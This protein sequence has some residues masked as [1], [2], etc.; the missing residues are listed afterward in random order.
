MPDVIKSNAAPTALT[1]TA[2]T[3]YTTPGSTTALVRKITVCNVTDSSV[4][5][6]ASKG[7]DAVA[8]RVVRTTIPAGE[9]LFLPIDLPLAA[10]EV[11]QMWCNV[12]GAVNVILTIVETT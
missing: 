3:V 9:T 11:I 10:A 7:T 4:M 5:V 8:T 2:A 1:A 12:S 6:Y